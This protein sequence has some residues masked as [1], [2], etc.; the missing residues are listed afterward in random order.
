[1]KPKVTI[2]SLGGT[3]AS[4][5]RDHGGV[6]PTLTADDLVAALP[7]LRNV[8]DITAASF[9]QMPSVEL[10]L[11]D[12]VALA[13]EILRQTSEGAD[14]VVVAQG[15]DTIEETSFALDLLV[16]SDAPV[17]VTGAMRNPTLPGPEGNANLLAAVSLAASKIARGLGT[18]VVMNDEIH[19]AAHAQKIHTQSPAAFSSITG[20]IGWFAEGRPFVAARPPRRLHLPM[21]DSANHAVALLKVALGDDGRLVGVIQDLGYHGL[22]VEAMGGGHVPAKMVE[23]LTNM[24]A[25]MPVVLA[26]RTRR[27]EVLTATYGFP[28]S[29]SDLLNR[30][31]IPAGWLDGLKAR[32]LLELLVSSGTFDQQAIAQTFSAFL[33]GR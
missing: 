10:T 9:Q 32:L 14:G 31:L 15:T 20:P 26:S 12:V 30:S 21:P 22:V 7:Q 11:E 25:E 16:D 3:I 19:A 8:A 28:G 27:G 2:F 18:V 17:V 13:K 1:M 6:V 23:H 4:A 29:E 5:G 33:Y 24:A